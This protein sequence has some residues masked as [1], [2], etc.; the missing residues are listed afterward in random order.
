M[1]D[2]W[3]VIIPADPQF[4]PSA[5]GKEKVSV[6]LAELAPNSETIKVEAD[7]DIV[8]FFDC[9]ENFESV[10]CGACGV[11]IGDSEWGDWMSADFGSGPGFT[12]TSKELSCCGTPQTL[13][14]LSYKMQQGF[15][16]FCVSAMNFDRGPLNSTE[17]ERLSEALGA[18]VRVITR[19]I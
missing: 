8:R 9:G 14:D 18:P 16:R 4:R 17:V 11:D 2:S 12:L 19:Y 13:N 1:S 7:G 10:R 3:L 6:V 5:S 15:A